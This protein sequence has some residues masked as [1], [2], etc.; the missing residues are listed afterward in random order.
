MASPIYI[1]SLVFGAVC[2][3]NLTQEVGLRNHYK[4][5]LSAMS[6][7]SPLVLDY[8]HMQHYLYSAIP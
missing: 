3:G 5:K 4:M 7:D 2:M 1:M 6:Q 8:L